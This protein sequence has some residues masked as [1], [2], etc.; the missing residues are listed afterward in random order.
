MWDWYI[1]GAS[2]RVDL[3]WKSGKKNSIVVRKK[4]SQNSRRNRGIGG[5]SKNTEIPFHPERAESQECARRDSDQGRA[6]T[7]RSPFIFGA[8]CH[9]ITFPNHAG[10]S[11]PATKQPTVETVA[12]VLDSRDGDPMHGSIYGALFLISW[13]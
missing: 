9:P 8:H 13:I 2:R 5:A 11:H 6:S 10:F 3:K 12:G 7:N 1:F 4:K